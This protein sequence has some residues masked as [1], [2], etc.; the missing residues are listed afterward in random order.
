MPFNNNIP[1]ANDK[2]ST[3]QADINGNFQAVNTYVN[4]DHTAFNIADQGKHKQ[5]SFIQQ[6][7]DPATGPTEAALYTKDSVAVPGTAGLFYRPPNSGAVAEFSYALKANPGWTILPSG[8]IMKWGSF[9]C[10]PGA[11]N[12]VYVAGAGIPNFAGILTG[13]ISRDGGGGA[14]QDRAISMTAL[15]LLQ[16]DI[17]NH[18]AA[19]KVVYYFVLGY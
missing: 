1:L 9:F 8:I 2:L 19:A 6:A 7:A 18:N 3:S 4:V 14:N 13:Q 15:G 10:N 11:G 16:I 5:I 17:W 12:A